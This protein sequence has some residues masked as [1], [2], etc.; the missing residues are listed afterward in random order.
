M[1]DS[2]RECFAVTPPGLEAICVQELVTLGLSPREPVTGG[3]EFCGEIRDIYLANLW[4]RSAN[5][6]LV[7]LGTLTARDFPTLYQRLVRLPWGRYIKPGT[8]CDVRAV[9]QRSRL[10]HTG[11][12][13][14]VCREAINKALGSSAVA[15][16]PTQMVLLRVN[17]DQVEVSI[18][19]SGD[20]LHRRGYRQA[21]SAA[22][23]RENLAAAA[24]L[25]CGYDGTL[26]LVDMMTGSGTFVIE[27]GLIAAN[28]APG[29]SRDFSFMLWP[30]FRE[31]LWRQLLKVAK[32]GERDDG[33][34]PIYGV[35][36]NPKAIAAARANVERAELVSGVEVSH[37][38]LQNLVPPGASGLMIGNPPYG[39]RLGGSTDLRGFYADIEYLC[40]EVFASWKCALLCPEAVA[41]QMRKLKLTPVLGFSHG[42][43][44]VFLF[45]GNS[46]K[47][48]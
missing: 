18:D 24:L 3:V 47:T 20:H 44:R 26:P 40:S 35:D 31:Q 43:I 25:A 29:I 9:S 34:A 1:K 30:K 14:A 7:R 8:A 10:L 5:R 12:I 17:D 21:R 39:T 46:G 28:K 37:G 11:R 19:S 2:S 15:T 32:E 27:A 36:N 42:G 23:L 22:P 45:V 41:V 6:I 48:P 16:G 13:C 33:Y 38:K 4:L